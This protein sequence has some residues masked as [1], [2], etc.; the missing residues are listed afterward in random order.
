MTVRRILLGQ[1]VHIGTP[2]EDLEVILREIRG[3]GRERE[4]DFELKGFGNLVHKVLSLK[5][6]N[7]P[8]RYN[9]KIG[10]CKKVSKFGDG[11]KLSFTY[12]PENRDYFFNVEDYD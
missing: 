5:N 1:G 11:V 6:R 10:I 8:D 3:R 9:V 12:P 4:Y 7:L 2:M